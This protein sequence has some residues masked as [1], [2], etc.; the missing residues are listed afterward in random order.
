MNKSLKSRNKPVIKSWR[1]RVLY[2]REMHN[3]IYK[4]W[5]HWRSPKLDLK[6]KLGRT[7]K[8]LF[9][10]KKRINKIIAEIKTYGD[11]IKEAYGKSKIVQFFQQAYL[12]FIVGVEYVEYRNYLLFK[13]K[14][15]KSVREFTYKHNEVKRDFISEGTYRDEYDIIND[16]VEFYNHCLKNGIPTPPVLSVINLNNQEELTLP[17]RDIFIKIVDGARG[18]GAAKFY[19]RNN[20]Y[21]DTT[22]K[23]FEPEDIIKLLSNNEYD[24]FRRGKFIVQPVLQN[25]QDW[26]PFTSGALATC[27]IVTGRGINNGE[28]IPI[29]A[30]LRMPIGTQIVDNLSD[31]GIASPI[32]LET[33]EMGTC[34]CHEPINKSFEVDSHPDTSKKIKGTVLPRWD[35]LLNFTAQAHKTFEFI[36]IAWDISYTTEGFVVVEANANFAEDLVESPQNCPLSKTQYPNLF[37]QWLREFKNRKSNGD[38]YSEAFTW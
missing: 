25:H 20:H 33:G 4:I 10:I 18:V 31:G 8:E 14:R 12:E 21:E 15:W 29:A 26:R 30:S 38:H 24:Y 35:E 3:P 1:E 23:V 36:F 9:L 27:R 16:K 17:K 22:G 13:K 34:I 19:Y 2:Y 5:R 11:V 28:I 6:T 32:N 7:H 37:N